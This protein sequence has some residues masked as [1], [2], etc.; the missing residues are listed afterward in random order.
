MVDNVNAPF[1][2][3]TV[4]IGGERVP[5]AVAGDQRY[6][7]RGLLPG[8]VQTSDLFEDWDANLDRIEAALADPGARGRIPSGPVDSGRILPPVQPIG[9][10]LAAGANYREHILQMSVAH[11]LGRPGANDAELWAEA[12]KENDE[13]RAHGDPYV[14]TG[15]PSAVSGAFD[16]VQLPEVGDDI[17][18]ELEL[19]VV[20]GRAGHHIPIEEAFDHIAGYTI[21]NDVSARSLIPRPDVAN[22][23]TDWFRGKNQPTFFP[24]GPWLV[25]ARYVEDPGDLRITLKLNGDVMQDASTDDLMFDVPSLISYVSSYAIIQPG[26]LLITGS[27]A[28]NG[29]HWQRFLRDG[30]V[31][32]G[33]I[34]GL[35]LQRTPVR[36]A[37]GVPPPWQRSRR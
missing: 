11:R 34:T 9:P 4:G 2:L 33:A 5:V 25:P 3:G 27:P 20:I 32:E 12:A 35:G 10:I 24:T 1:V 6:D 23:G 21:V 30:D 15:I 26:D 13:R 7:L 19:G 16:D 17:D 8:I 37:K 29:S 22:I 31:M 28:G 18:W 36:G 14:W